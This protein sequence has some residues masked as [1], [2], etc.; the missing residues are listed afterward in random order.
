MGMDQNIK[1]DSI[2]DIKLYNNIFVA[3]FS[4]KIMELYIRFFIYYFEYL[5]T[6]IA[7]ELKTF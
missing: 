2:N 4:Q 6:K 1:E 7:N 5:S 3:Y